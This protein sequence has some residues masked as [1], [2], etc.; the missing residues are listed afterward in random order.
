MLVVLPPIFVVDTKIIYCYNFVAPLSNHLI[1][2][3]AFLQILEM[4]FSKFSLSISLPNHLAD[5][6]MI[7]STTFIF[8]TDLLRSF[9]ELIILQIYLGLLLC[10]LL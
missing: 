2:I 9:L 7:T 5:D 3:I 1:E 4:C 6:S 8:N 10:Y